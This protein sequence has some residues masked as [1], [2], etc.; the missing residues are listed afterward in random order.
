MDMQAYFTALAQGI[1]VGQLTMFAR[2]LEYQ[3]GSEQDGFWCPAE[4]D[5]RRRTLFV[6]S[7]S[8]MQI[9]DLCWRGII[10]APGTPVD[11]PPPLP[12]SLCA[13]TSR[14]SRGAS[15]IDD[16]LF[17][18]QVYEFGSSL[19]LRLRT[20]EFELLLAAGCPATIDGVLDVLWRRIGQD[21][22]RLLSPARKRLRIISAIVH[23]RTD[24]ERQIARIRSLVLPPGETD[25]ALDRLDAAERAV[26][27]AAM[28]GY[29]N[30]TLDPALRA[31]VA[32]LFVA[33]DELAQERDE[34]LGHPI[35]RRLR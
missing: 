22:F 10:P 35:P 8:R 14:L 29:A 18:Q 6:R 19:R 12:V 4:L 31:V 9:S 34:R 21:W 26:L 23:H 28:E 32:N 2:W 7:L 16:P 33:D 15:L 30:N 1:F 3:T 17:E 27:D 13:E 20:G 25:G 11:S 24:P 5:Q